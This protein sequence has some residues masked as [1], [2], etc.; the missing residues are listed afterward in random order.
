M[1]LAA[2]GSRPSPEW[3]RARWDQQRRDTADRVARAVA[4]LRAQDRPV[5]F[6]AI[7]DTVKDLDGVSM[8]T[9][10]IQR[11]D[12]AYAIYEQYASRR[13]SSGRRHP[14]LSAVLDHAAASERPALRTKVTRLRRAS[15]DEL[16][17]SLIELAREVKNQQRREQ[18]LRD[19]LLRVTIGAST[20]AT[21]R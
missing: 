10:T 9:N 20:G 18:A 5:T 11:N 13:A 16:I 12:L 3:L 15:K 17:A 8:S 21:T 4:R 1:A 6:A 7:R 19:E 14:S 2:N